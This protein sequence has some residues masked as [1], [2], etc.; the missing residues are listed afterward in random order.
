MG[1]IYWAMATGQWPEDALP[2]FV[3]HGHEM[4][5]GFAAAAI[6]GFLLTAVPTWTGTRAVSGIA[7][8]ALVLLWLAGRVASSPWVQPAS[9]ATQFFGMAF[10]PALAITVAIPLVRTRNLRNLLFIPLLAVLFLGE[11]AF[12]VRYFAWTEGQVFDGLRLTINAVMLL[13][14]IIGGRIVP[15]FTRNALA[16]IRRD[17]TIRSYP[18]VDRAAILSVVGVLLGDIFAMDSTSTGL[19]AALSAG[20]IFVRLTGWGGLRTF[21]IPLLWVLHLGFCWLIVALSLKALWL[22]GGFA[23]AMNWMHAFTAGVFGTMILGVMTRVALGHTGRPL[24]VP[25]AVVVAYVLVSA[26]AL[27]RVFGPWFA[28]SHYTLVLAVS[29]AAWASAFAI[30]LFCYT[31]VLLTPR[32]DGQGG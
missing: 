17:V 5:F 18:A 14:V 32:P 19:L 12:H 16:A 4:L 15:A 2:L 25:A 23:F 26:A 27:I 8:I 6:A 29:V 21:D 28:Q 31:P 10:L 13:V 7:L 20:L 1:T 30:F 11:I 3:W 22:L 24:V 9:T